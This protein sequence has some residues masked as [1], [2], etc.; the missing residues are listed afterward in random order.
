MFVNIRPLTDH[1][2]IDKKEREAWKLYTD[3]K[4]QYESNRGLLFVCY[5]SSIDNGFFRQTVQYANNDYF[6]TTGIIPTKHGE[7]CT[8][9]L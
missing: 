7:L 8:L 4:K 9:L 5:Q 6:P 1:S 3:E 2:Q